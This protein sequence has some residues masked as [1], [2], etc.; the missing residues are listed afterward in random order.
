MSSGAFAGSPTTG[1]SEPPPLGPYAL[2]AAVTVLAVLSQYFVP[3]AVP[4][5]RP[6]YGSLLGGLGI[7]YGIPLVAFSLLVGRAPLSA[8]A[9][10]MGRATWEGLR[11]Y[12]LLSLLGLLISFVLVIVYTALDPGALDF[13]QRP[14]PVLQQASTNPWLYVGL[15][16]LVGACEET[17]FRGW[18]FGFWRDRPGTSWV[19]HATWTSLVFAGVHVYYAQ[20]YGPASPFV[21]PTLFLLGFAFAATYQASGGN[22]V[23]V[24][25]LHGLNDAAGFLSILSPTGAIGLHYGIV[26]VGV[27]IGILHAA[28]VGPGARAARPPPPP[29]APWGFAPPAWPPLPPPPPPPPPLGTGRGQALPS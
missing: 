25:A 5:L 18:L 17:I 11:W 14:N 24:I 16:F 27:V 23:V 10:R 29:P 22:L 8:F 12:G 13:L 9:A 15:S 4:A 21:Y 28:G 20:T 3:Q 6:I 2:A 1:G 7:V 19:V 26:L